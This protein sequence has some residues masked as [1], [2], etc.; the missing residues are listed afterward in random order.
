MKINKVLLG[1]IL[2]AWTLF[3]T[4]PIY[5]KRIALPIKSQ[6]V[7]KVIPKPVIKPKQQQTSEFAQGEVIVKFKKPLPTMNSKV[8]KQKTLL[9]RDLNPRTMPKS[10]INTNKI[11][12]LQKIQKISS[13]K[14]ELNKVYLL[15]FKFQDAKAILKTFKNNPEVEYAS[16]NYKIEFY[17]NNDPL[18]GEQWYFFD[19]ANNVDIDALEAYDLSAYGVVPKSIE[20]P[21]AI[22]DQPMYIGHSDL[23]DSLWVNKAEIDNDGLDNDNNGYIDDYNGC[24]FGYVDPHNPDCDIHG[25][26]PA[27]LD[28]GTKVAG[29]VGATHNNN[30]G[31]KG[32]CPNCKVMRAGVPYF[33]YNVFEAIN[34]AVDNG[35][36]V[37]NM[38]WG[39]TGYPENFDALQEVLNY[40]HSQNVTLVAAPGNGRGTYVHAP[41]RMEHV[42]AVSALNEKNSKAEFSTYGEQI[43]LSAPGGMSILTTYHGARYP[44]L[45]DS[46]FTTTGTSFS[47]PMVAAAAGMLLSYNP[48]L[49]PDQIE[50]TLKDTADPILYNNENEIGKMGAGRLNIFRALYKS[51]NLKEMFKN[52]SIASVQC[53]ENRTRLEIRDKNNVKVDGKSAEHIIDNVYSYWVDNEKTILIAGTGWTTKMTVPKTCRLTSILPDF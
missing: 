40:A 41:A 1:L 31:I 16:L 17:E 33:Y 30:L 20:V 2:I 10:L 52:T 43:D 14:N 44:E 11:Y 38:S 21:V 12:S 51:L 26:A 13:K 32:A 15:K 4:N 3:L 6:V 29:I 24:F 7:N 42:I 22:V 8:S 19:S 47:S 37:I 27:V 34:Y 39:F 49:T 35:A 48:S 28:H 46:Y 9:Y 5:A 53:F 23:K 25:G 45:Y 18:F 36:K 50:S